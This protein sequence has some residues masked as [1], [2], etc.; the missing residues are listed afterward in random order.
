MQLE[1]SII[2]ITGATA[3][4]GAATATVLAQSRCRL[5]LTGRR[6][7]RLN[8]LRSKL[9]LGP[10]RHLLIA[11]DITN[12]AFCNHLIEQ[13]IAHFGRIDVLINNAG[14]GHNSNLAE[15]PSADFKKIWET[16]L[17]GLAWLSQA[18][19]QAMLAQAVEP[20]SSRRGQIINVSSIVGDRPLIKQGIYTASKAAVNGYSRGLRMELAKIKITVSLVYPGLTA[21]EFHTAKLG[22][23]RK[24]NFRSAGIE[25]SQVAKKIQNA[26]IKQKSEVYVTF[27]DW[28]F[29][30]ANR[31]FPR[32]TDQ[33]FKHV[34]NG[35]KD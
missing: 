16:N 12:E 3:G 19:A 13:T 15:I 4:I 31:H 11:G 35:S 20:H 22:P 7:E 27:Y 6:Q 2:V 9:N 1:D 33:V 10:D 32:L 26:I 17:Y 34:A 18:A 28:F 8:E 24:P 29:V 30:Q 5:V 21:T 25:P 14:I 23:K